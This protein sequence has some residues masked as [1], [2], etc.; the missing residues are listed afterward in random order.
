MSDPAYF[1]HIDSGWG[2]PTE[3]FMQLPGWNPATKDADIADG[4]PAAGRGV[5]TGQ[6]A[7]DRSVRHPVAEPA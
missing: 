7:A 6:P 4:K 1:L 2:K 5:W 3:E